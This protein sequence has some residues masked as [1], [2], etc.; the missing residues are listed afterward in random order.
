MTSFST[1]IDAFLSKITDDM[2]L[3]LTEED[4]IRD[5]KQYLLDAIPYFEFPRFPLFDYDA[6]AGVYNVDLTKEEINIFAILMK[7]AWLDRQIN[8][9]ENTRMKY[10]GSDFKFTSQANHLQK[11]LS[12]KAENHRENIHAQRLYKRRRLR[13]DTS[14]MSNWMVLNESALD[15]QS[16]PTQSS[17]INAASANSNNQY[18]TIIN[19]YG[20]DDS[21]VYDWEP[22]K[23]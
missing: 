7:Q 3:E 19:N 21:A 11:L 18:I 5:A 8:S 12:L 2:Y 6:E 1:I 22:I 23:Q 17:S 15:G 14:V 9:V 10:S 13:T 16:S 20:D 4:T